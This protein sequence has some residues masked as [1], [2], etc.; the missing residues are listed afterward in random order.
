ME[1][2]RHVPAVRVAAGCLPEVPPFP[3]G[4]K[5]VKTATPGNS[6]KCFCTFSPAITF[7]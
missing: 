7:F 1:F 6:P 5:I 2:L 4:S 3:P